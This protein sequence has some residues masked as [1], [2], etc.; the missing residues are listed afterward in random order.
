MKKTLILLPLLTGCFE[1]NPMNLGGEDED[2]SDT[3]ALDETGAMPDS[4]GDETP[5]ADETDGGGETDG[6][7]EPEGDTDAADPPVNCNLDTHTCLSNV[8]LGWNGPVADV[9]ANA[10][11]GCQ[12][13]FPEAAFE[14]YEAVV[15]DPAV[16]TCDCGPAQG[17]SCADDVTVE[18]YPVESTNQSSCQYQPVPDLVAAPGP[19][20][21]AQHQ[22]YD[23]NYP[24]GWDT[25]DARFIAH[26]PSVETPGTCGVAAEATE[27]GEPE[28]LDAR[29]AC[30]PAVRFDACDADTI[31]V[32]NPDVPFE[33]GVCIWAEGHLPCPA[34]TDFVNREVRQLGVVDDRACSSCSCGDAVDQSC[35]DAELT[36]LRLD[37]VVYTLED[38]WPEY[39]SH[40]YPVDGT[41]TFADLEGAREWT[42]VAATP[43]E[44]S[45]GSCIEQGGD[46]QGSVQAEQ[47]I[48]YCC[49]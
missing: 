49:T 22:E 1:P 45:G 44:P 42:A 26:P 18:L 12:G 30:A 13:S 17:G 24:S 33:T 19:I 16:C 32:P 43:G 10:S 34:G 5:P 31:C 37:R 20:F 38:S 15:A 47:Q 46:P 40:Q 25:Y 14:N 3:E 27:L 6:G 21:V 9:D 28:L 8:P 2:E 35:N 29:Q 36:L 23:G 11:A 41:C 7:M 39:S 4:E 48:T